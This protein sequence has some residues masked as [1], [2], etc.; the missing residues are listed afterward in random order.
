MKFF[1]YFFLKVKVNKK[2]KVASVLC[3]VAVVGLSLGDALTGHGIKYN[4]NLKPV[5][6]GTGGGETCGTGSTGT[7]NQTQVYRIKCEEYVETGYF[8]INNKFGLCDVTRITC[9]GKGPVECEA[10]M[11]LY[12]KWSIFF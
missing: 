7:G 8:C 11:M 9:E 1:T 4:K 6:M 10:G 2:S 5:V 12:C 3:A